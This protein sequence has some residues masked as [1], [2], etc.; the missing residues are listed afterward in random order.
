MLPNCHDYRGIELYIQNYSRATISSVFY[1]KKC[2][3]KSQPIN[4]GFAQLVVRANNTLKIR[5]LTNLDASEPY[6]DTELDF[7][8]F[9]YP[10][11]FPDGY[12]NN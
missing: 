4:L 2:V 8:A 7:N 10:E 11:S 12:S 5:I 9:K 1:D 3:L 6:V